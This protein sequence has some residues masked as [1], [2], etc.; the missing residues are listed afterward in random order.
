[1]AF[2]KIAERSAIPFARG[3][4]ERVFGWG[5]V[6]FVCHVTSLAQLRAER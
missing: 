2:E 5:G 1:M 6:A 3:Q 4:E